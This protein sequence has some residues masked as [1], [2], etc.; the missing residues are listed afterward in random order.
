MSGVAIVWLVVGVTTM[1]LLVACLLQLVRQVR[2]LT[3]S[4]LQ[5]Q[6][7][8]T[9]VLESIQRDTQA[10][11]EHSDRLQRQAEALRSSDDGQGGKP[12]S[13]PAARTRG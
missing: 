11:Q 4:M 2:R 6:Q 13:H 1:L 8:V 10:A 9:P 12:R 3:S 5:F 7:E